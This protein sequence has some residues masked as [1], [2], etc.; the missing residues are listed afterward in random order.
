MRLK[1]ILFPAPLV[2]NSNQRKMQQQKIF[3][4]GLNINIF[5][6]SMDSWSVLDNVNENTIRNY[7]LIN[8]NPILVCR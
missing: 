4:K 2:N 1:V 6:M 3:F 8:T 7:H 5:T